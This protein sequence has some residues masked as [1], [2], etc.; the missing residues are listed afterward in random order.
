MAATAT[1]FWGFLGKAR[2][3]T[4]SSFVCLQ[5]SPSPAA[6]NSS[7]VCFDGRHQQELRPGD[8]FVLAF[9]NCGGGACLLGIGKPTGL[10]I[11][12]AV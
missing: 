5:I 10:L 7:F 8:R 12:L 3:Q 11:G 1:A 4:L 9:Q 2:L 6:R